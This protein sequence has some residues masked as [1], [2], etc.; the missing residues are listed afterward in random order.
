VGVGYDP[1][2][3]W[4]EQFLEEHKPLFRKPRL[5]PVAGLRVTIHPKGVHPITVPTDSDGWVEVDL[6]PG[7]Y[8]V[9]CSGQTTRVR[10]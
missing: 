2:M 8:D 9:V 5:R 1:A 4:R 3:V 6:P 7:E 10:V